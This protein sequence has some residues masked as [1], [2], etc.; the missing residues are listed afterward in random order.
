LTTTPESRTIEP[1]IEVNGR[2]AAA[3][4]GSEAVTT[5]RDRALTTALGQIERTHGKGAIMRLGEAR[6]QRVEAIPTGALTLDIALGVGGVPRGRVIE[7]YGPESS[8][9]TTLTLHIIAEAQKLGGVAAFIDAEHALDPQYAGRIGVNTDELLISQPDTGEQALEIVEV[10]VR[11][12]AVDVVVIDSVAALVPK[13]EIDGEMGDSHVGLQA[14]LMSQAMRKLTAAIS[15]SNTCV[16]F[17]NQLREKIGVMFGN[18]ETTTGGRALKFYASVRMDIRKID[19]IKQGL[20][21]VGNRV[22]V[23]VVK[24]KIAAP[25]RVAEFD[26]LYN[27][28]IS[29]AGSVLDIAIDTK[30]VDKSGAW[31]SYGDMRLGQGRENVRDFL[32]QNADLLEEIAGK[33][34]VQSLPDVTPLDAP[35]TNGVAPAI[36]VGPAA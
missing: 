18:P 16:I 13:A 2:R 27:E 19:S 36:P 11:S 35:D 9:K 17:I 23:K 8:G 5:E 29:Y 7:I 1:I 32:R 3:V 12:G 10:L 21:V 20:D 28:G 33:V 30:V 25:F 14:R 34:K 24:N 15:R 26:I 6:T 31:F 4:K 22:K